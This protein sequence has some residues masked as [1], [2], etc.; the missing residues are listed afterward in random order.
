MCIEIRDL[1]SQSVSTL[2]DGRYQ[3]RSCNAKSTGVRIWRYPII[4]A[5]RPS[6]VIT[7]SVNDNIMI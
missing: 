4:V 6:V 5:F 2:Y 1:S 7:F 3:G